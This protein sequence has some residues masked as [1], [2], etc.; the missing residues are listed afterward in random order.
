MPAPR[1]GG[2]RGR[3][4]RGRPDGRRR[5]RVGSVR[6]VCRAACGRVVRHLPHRR[7]AVAHSRRD[8]GAGRRRRRR[9]RNRLR[10]GCRAVRRKAAPRL[11]DGLRN[12]AAGAGAGAAR[13]A[14]AAA[15]PFAMST[16]GRG[17]QR[18]R[19]S[20][21][22]GWPASGGAA[23]P[24]AET[25]AGLGAGWAAWPSVL[26]Q[27]RRPVIRRGKPKGRSGQVPAWCSGGRRK[28][29]WGSSSE[30]RRRRQ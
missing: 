27:D 28:N 7:R 12:P 1:R 19:P 16:R 17:R 21:R 11:D 10:V 23:R 15:A 6:L 25:Q 20:R 18:R 30:G 14:A 22:L 13:N 24:A 4:R 8:R 5:G 29:G 2:G 26:R 3:L 9:S